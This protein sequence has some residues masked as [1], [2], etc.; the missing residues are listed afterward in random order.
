[1]FEFEINKSSSFSV[2]FLIA[3]GS[4]L[5]AFIVAHFFWFKLLLTLCCILSFSYYYPRY[6]SLTHPRV[7]KKVLRQLSGQ[8]LLEFKD[9]RTEAVNILG[10]SLVTNCVVV[11][12]FKTV[13]KRR[14]SVVIFPDA[15]KSQPFRKLLVLLRHIEERAHGKGRH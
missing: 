8:W 1:M 6:I 4:F 7:I 12:N 14:I 5:I 2:L 10:D 13:T 11:L 15:I 9:G 3:H